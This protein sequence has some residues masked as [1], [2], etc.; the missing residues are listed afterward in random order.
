MPVFGEYEQLRA[1]PEPGYPEYAGLRAEAERA[2]RG[3]VNA[4]G[5][6]TGVRPSSATRTRAASA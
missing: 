5:A 2:A 1:N 3:L 6:T 4:A